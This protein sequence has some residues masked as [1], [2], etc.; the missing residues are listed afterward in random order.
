M[1]IDH[2]GHYF[3]PEEPWFR[4]I[5]RLSVPIWFFLIG[6]A[7]TRNV[8]WIIW[9]GGV[10]LT[11]SAIA[12][13]QTIFP[14]SIL[15]ILGLSRLMI[16]EI[17]RRAL[18]NYE[19]L[20]G[21][22][23]LLLLLSFHSAALIEYGTVGVLFVMMG[24][25]R[26]HQG[27]LTLKPYIWWLFSAG[28]SCAYIMHQALW[29]GGM[30]LEQILFFFFG[31]AGFCLVF[32]IFKPL[33]FEGSYFLRPILQITGRHTLVIY[34]GHLLLFRV[35]ALIF[36]PERFSFSGFKFAPE[37]LGIFLGVL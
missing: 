5:G 31:M 12:T 29:M 37:G 10:V 36:F 8:P 3:S 1:V 2:T 30:T 14:L 18:R 24:Y 34:I 13:G 28:V 35:I 16:D 6:Y 20:A 26:R 11:I 15:F 21:M 22:F 32:S 9:G 23:F 19:A 17:M 7:R 25:L 4:I 33:Q 27:D